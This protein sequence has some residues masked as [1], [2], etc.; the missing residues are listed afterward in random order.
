[1][2]MERIGRERR[3]AK[4]PVQTLLCLSLSVSIYL[5]L[6]LPPLGLLRHYLLAPAIRPLPIPLS[7]GPLSGFFCFFFFFVLASSPR[8]WQLTFS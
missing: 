1:M 7:T 6:Y 5:C 2:L 8:A 3:E 4:L